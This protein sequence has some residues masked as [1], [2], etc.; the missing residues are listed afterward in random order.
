MGITTGEI[1]WTIEAWKIPIL[2]FHKFW[3]HDFYIPCGFPDAQEDY[4]L[5]RSNNDNIIFF[6]IMCL[7]LLGNILH[8]Y[9]ISTRSTWEN[10][11]F[12]IHLEEKHEWEK[13]IRAYCLHKS[14]LKGSQW[15]IFGKDKEFCLLILCKY[16]FAPG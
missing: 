2:I 10:L 13:P 12:D 15:N 6:N 14:T 5:S 3:L 7:L 9:R 1:K 8:C 16:F 4:S 11:R